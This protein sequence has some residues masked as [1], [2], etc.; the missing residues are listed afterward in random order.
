MLWSDF[1]SALC[2]IGIEDENISREEFCRAKEKLENMGGVK[3]LR[4]MTDKQ[5]ARGFSY[6]DDSNDDQIE[7]AEFVHF[8][9]KFIIT[10]EEYLMKAISVSVI[11]RAWIYMS[12]PDELKPLIYRQSTLTKSPSVL[13]HV[14]EEDDEDAVK[15]SHPT[16]IN[17]ANNDDDILFEALIKQVKGSQR[18]LIRTNSNIK[19]SQRSITRT[20]SDVPTSIHGYGDMP[21]VEEISQLEEGSKADE[22]KA[23]I[24]DWT[25]R[26]MGENSQDRFLKWAGSLP[27]TKTR[28]PYDGVDTPHREGAEEEIMEEIEVEVEGYLNMDTLEVNSPAFAL[29]FDESGSQQSVISATTL[30]DQAEQSK[31]EPES[32]ISSTSYVYGGG[33]SLQ[34]ENTNS[35]Q[36][37]EVHKAHP[38]SPDPRYRN[39]MKMKNKKFYDF[40]KPPCFAFGHYHRPNKLEPIEDT[41]QLR[42]LMKE[43]AKLRAS[44]RDGNVLNSLA[45]NVKRNMIKPGVQGVALNEGIN[46][47]RK[48]DEFSVN[49]DVDDLS[50]FGQMSF[51]RNQRNKLSISNMAAHSQGNLVTSTPNNNIEDKFACMVEGSDNTTVATALDQPTPTTINVISLIEN[52]ILAQFE[53]D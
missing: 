18:N 52:L 41:S 4:P 5:W 15:E 14:E 39:S 7:F 32:S 46:L 17:K 29:D 37:E 43:R 19:G 36:P 25:D 31:N 23:L 3:V 27:D 8:C 40:G 22:T 12:S 11:K 38:V 1:Y 26:R 16:I 50:E 30:L 6:I 44:F 53:T 9:M 28:Q 2:F 34:T 42:L 13:N 24:S 21:S 51:N 48:K 33:F 10:P 35:Y 45:C 49:D 20:N 47:D